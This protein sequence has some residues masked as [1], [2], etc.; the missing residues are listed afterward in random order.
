MIFILGLNYN[1]SLPG[2]SIDENCLFIGLG[3]NHPAGGLGGDSRGDNFSILGFA[4]NDGKNAG[5]FIWNFFL[6]PQFID[7]QVW[8]FYFIILFYEATFILAVCSSSVFFV[9]QFLLLEEV[10]TRFKE[11]RGYAPSRVIFYRSGCSE[12]RFSDFLRY[13]VP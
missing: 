1:I 12:G 5:E 3:T 6:Q 10:F 8:L 2:N 4:A 11:N 9:Q 13:E 7:E